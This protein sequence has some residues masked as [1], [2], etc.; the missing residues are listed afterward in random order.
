M[1][2]CATRPVPVTELRKGDRIEARDRYQQRYVGIVD[3]V[4]REL[5]MV[6]IRETHLGE[7]KLLDPTEHRLYRCPA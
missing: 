6:W 3:L 1:H 4:A 2:S 5:G 7:R